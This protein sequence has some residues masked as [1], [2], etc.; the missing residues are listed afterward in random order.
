M[1]TQW[2]EKLA[3]GT[4]VLIRPIRPDDAERERAF[5]EGLSQQSRYF[6]FLDA[7]RSPSS[8][9]IKQLTEID[10]SR[11]AAFAALIGA[12]PSQRIIGVARYSLCENGESCECA[13]SVADEFQR[14]G[15]G[16]LL[17]RHLIEHAR[18]HGIK[19]L[20][21]LDAADNGSMWGFAKRLGFDHKIDEQDSSLVIHRLKLG[22]A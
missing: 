16:T 4:S 18:V 19:S 10:Q 9:L 20:Y 14:R 3:D 2:S 15:L 8:A 5:I 1:H 17:M 12:E 22:M 7:M 11:D 6:R 21:S 13:V